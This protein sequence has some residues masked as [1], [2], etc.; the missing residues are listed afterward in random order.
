[1]RTLVLATAALF[2][3]TVVDAK[4]KGKYV[5]TFDKCLANGF[6]STMEGCSATGEGKMNK[7]QTKKC[8]K[9]EMDL[10]ECEYV[11]KV[12]EL[13]VDGGWSD[14]G[15]WS[16]CSAECGGGSQIRSKTCTSPSPANG[17]KECEGENEETKSCNPEPCP[18]QS[19]FHVT[20]HILR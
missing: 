3:L 19:T 15:E 9:V 13:A 4:C 16:V 1:M 20:C 11:C 17:G 6:K 7:R 8:V 2:I 12:D 10:K 18:G 5:K 14:F